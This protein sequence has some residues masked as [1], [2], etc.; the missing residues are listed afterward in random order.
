MDDVIQGA[1][2]YNRK[3][4]IWYYSRYWP[5]WSTFYFLLYFSPWRFCRI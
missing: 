2:L 3:Y 4:F 5:M 1:P